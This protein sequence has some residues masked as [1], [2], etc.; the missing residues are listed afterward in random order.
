MKRTW[1][2]RYACTNNV[3]LRFL[4][5][6]V[7]LHLLGSESPLFEPLLEEVVQKVDF[8]NDEYANAAYSTWNMKNFNLN[9]K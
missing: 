2:V 6:Q 8:N 3:H 4:F 7:A 1:E 9:Y 5:P